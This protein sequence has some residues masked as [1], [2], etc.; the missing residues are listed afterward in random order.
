MACLCRTAWR[1]MAPVH[2]A[3]M[4]QDFLRIAQSCTLAAHS[5]LMLPRAQW[6]RLMLPRAQFAQWSRLML[7]R[8]HS[9]SR[10]TVTISVARVLA[11]FCALLFQRAH[12]IVCAHICASHL[13]LFLPAHAYSHLL[14]P[15]TTN[16]PRLTCTLNHMCTP[17]CITPGHIFTYS[18]LITSTCTSHNEH[19]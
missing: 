17:T 16:T 9:L 4:H 2:K 11:V 10:V 18:R 13:V 19:T 15:R 12:L 5:R 1:I 8:A 3:P 7:P 14:A 6:S